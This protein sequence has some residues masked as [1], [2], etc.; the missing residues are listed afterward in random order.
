VVPKNASANIFRTVIVEL[1]CTVVSS[2]SLHQ[3]SK[4]P[5]AR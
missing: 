3:N 2:F 4:F 5:A 1:L